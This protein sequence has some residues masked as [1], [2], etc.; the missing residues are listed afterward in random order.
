MSFDGQNTECIESKEFNL[1]QTEVLQWT[2]E[3]YLS[4]RKKYP[5]LTDACIGG[6]VSFDEKNQRLVKTDAKGH[7]SYLQLETK[8]SVITVKA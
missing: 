5:D 3:N 8:E 2:R 6:F 7:R 4:I 1:L